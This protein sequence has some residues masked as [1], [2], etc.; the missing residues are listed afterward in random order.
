MW[1]LAKMFV[2]T[3]SNLSEKGLLF[4]QMVLQQSDSKIEIQTTNLPFGT[5]INC[6][7]DIICRLFW[8]LII[9][10]FY[11][12]RRVTWFFFTLMFNTM[13]TKP[14]I[15]IAVSFVDALLLK[16]NVKK[17]NR[18]RFMLKQKKADLKGRPKITSLTFHI[19][20][21]CSTV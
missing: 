5:L 16:K 7:L 11:I 14:P 4:Y 21:F 6:E 8:H 17:A 12:K 2:K 10:N 9:L 3:D 15:I 19:E 1:K 13:S 18:N 20:Y